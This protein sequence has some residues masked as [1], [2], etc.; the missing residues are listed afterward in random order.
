M[1]RTS[2]ALA[3]AHVFALSLTVAVVF[4]VGARPA[5]ACAMYIPHNE[6]VIV[7]APPVHSQVAANAAPVQP[8][9]PVQAAEPTDL[10]RAMALIDQVGLMGAA[11]AAE[12]EPSRGVESSRPPMA[13]APSRSSA[14]GSRAI[15]EVAE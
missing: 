12:I 8:V 5:H 10:Q 9:A 3:A 1:T 4:M 13:M 2:P 6:E 11:V 7:Q 15:A 14:S